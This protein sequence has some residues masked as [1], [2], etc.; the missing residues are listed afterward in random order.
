M[1]EL[2]PQ[3]ELMAEIMPL[4]A[5]T[6]VEEGEVLQELIMV[7]QEE[8]AVNLAEVAEGEVV[9]MVEQQELV[10]MEAEAK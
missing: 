2:H 1:E 7:V 5:E 8:M 4:A 3:Q 9:V 6:V 10:A